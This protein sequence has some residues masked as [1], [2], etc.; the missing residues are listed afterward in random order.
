[1]FNRG[2]CLAKPR[3]RY[4]V[5]SEA[6]TAPPPDARPRKILLVDDD[7][8]IL[9]IYGEGLARRGFQVATVAGGLKAMRLSKT[10]L[11]NHHIKRLPG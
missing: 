8:F 9:K 3:A 1:M 11:P 7:L 10:H 4:R 2:F 5:N 6:T